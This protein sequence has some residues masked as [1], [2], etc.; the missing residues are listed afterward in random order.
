MVTMVEREAT[1]ELLA[2]QQLEEAAK[3]LDVEPWIVRRLRHCEREIAV[4]LEVIRDNGDAMMFR[5]VRVQH[6]AARGPCMGPLMFSRHFS[7]GDGHALAMWL[8]WQSALWD[9]PFGGSAGWIGASLEELSE[10]E[11]R[12]LTRGYID[13][14]AGVIGAEKDIVTPE[15][16][17]HP[18]VSAWALNA[19][20][21]VSRKLATS[22]TGKPSSLGGVAREKVAALALRTLIESAL[23][24]QGMKLAGAQ[25][26]MAGFGRESR[27]VASA[28]DT[29]GARI[30]AVCDRSGAVFHRSR[31]EL[32]PL[33]EYLEKE[34]VV[35]GYPDA[36]S[37]SAEEMMQ[38][39][40]DVLIL[41]PGHD[42]LTATKARMVLEC[43]GAV[44]C[45]WS[46]KV[47][48]IPALLGDSGLRLADFLEWR[49]S[50]CGIVS[51]RELLR[52]MQALVRRTCNDVWEHS[53]K[54]EIR[55]D[56][57]A[58]AIAVGR[59]AQA[60]RMG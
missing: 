1:A 27:C 55:L 59:M 46:S 26:A 41:G 9:L 36:Q 44:N 50:A 23:R 48:V 4:S 54:Y 31:L 52:G 56:Q 40:F 12:L 24:S 13:S 22:V 49:K 32:P 53:Q 60:M 25:I 58:M 29:A 47:V 10:R 28:L 3:F 8:T 34:D 45:S 30:V 2:A 19:L 43:G 6:S 11:A 18:E 38:L 15:R 37:M 35:F 21:K 5:G 57:S 33:L 17:A 7:E 51:D 20:G 14:L 42:L 16:N 39:P